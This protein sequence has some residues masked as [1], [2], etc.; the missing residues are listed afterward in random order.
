M[1]DW[2]VSVPIIGALAVV[3]AWTAE[4]SPIL[5]DPPRRDPWSRP[6]WPRYITPK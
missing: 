2:R 1:G 3:L 5:V 4:L 6:C